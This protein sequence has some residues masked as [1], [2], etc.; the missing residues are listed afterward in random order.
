MSKSKRNKSKPAKKRRTKA[1]RSSS[2]SRA[3]QSSLRGGNYGP[4]IATKAARDA[5]R[6]LGAAFGA[7]MAAGFSKKKHTLSKAEKTARKRVRAAIAS[8]AGKAARLKGK[9]R[10]KVA[11]KKKRRT[12]S[13]APASKK[14]AS[15][16]RVP[17]VTANSVIAAAEKKALRRWVCEGAR[18]S[19]CG[20]GGSRVITAKGSFVR[21]RP[22][23]FMTSG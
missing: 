12:S 18:R 10:S 8:V 11:P 4:A 15:K 2:V 21:L 5:E 13:A 20:A 7:S 14:R 1:R 23:R 17:T 19:G 22:P 3:Y 9:K 6:A 16:K